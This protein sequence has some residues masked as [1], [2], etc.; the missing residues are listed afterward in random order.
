M[1]EDDFNAIVAGN[2]LTRKE[3]VEVGTSHGNAMDSKEE[4]P[5]QKWNWERIRF[6]SLYFL[7]TII[8]F[9][10]VNL[11]APNLSM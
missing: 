7:T 5:T 9:S 8:L 11:M 6:L 4:I 10:N 3:D 1:P 2:S